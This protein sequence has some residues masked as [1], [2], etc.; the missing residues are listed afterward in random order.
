MLLRYA[1]SLIYV[2]KLSH[3]YP[4]LKLGAFWR[5]LVKYS[6]IFMLRSFTKLYRVSEKVLQLHLQL[7]KVPF[8]LDTITLYKDNFFTKYAVSKSYISSQQV[9]NLS[10]IHNIFSGVILKL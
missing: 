2:T 4:Q 3:S 9:Y 1:R 7:Q 6:I 5:F 10:A 8:F